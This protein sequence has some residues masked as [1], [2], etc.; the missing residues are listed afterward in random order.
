MHRVTGAPSRID[1]QVGL[2]HPT[3][4]CI[5]ARPVGKPCAT[6][7][8]QERGVQMIA[9]IWHGAVPVEKSEAYL[10][11]MRAVALPGYRNVEG[12]Q[13]A[14]VMHRIEGDIAHFDM[15]T[16]WDNIDAIKRFAGEDYKVSQ[17]FDF[18]DDFLI[19]KE[20]HVRHWEMY[21]D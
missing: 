2:R 3:R 18:D 4:G 14:W 8:D 16:F 5:S 21:A 10:E 19:E 12:N 17:Y 11:K 7:N 20:P 1:L 6:A 9:R 13:G 15:L